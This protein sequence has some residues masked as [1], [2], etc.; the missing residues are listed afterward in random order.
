MTGLWLRW[1]GRD[2]RRRWLLVVAIALV[3][4]LGTGTYAALTSTSTWRTRSNDASFALLHLHD[5]EA[6]MS[7][8]STAPE[9]SLTAV[10]RGLPAAAD[11]ERVQERLIVP[12]QLS[13]RV[14]ARDVLTPGM[15][16]GTPP[17]PEDAAVDAL[18]VVAGRAPK[19]GEAGPT[20]VLEHK[21]ARANDLPD[22]GMLLVSG[23]RTVPYVGVGVT[24]EDFVVTGSGSGFIMVE[25][26][27]GVAY[28][29]LAGAQEIAGA[30]GRV[31]DV[32]LLL[33]PGADRGRLQQQLT[34]ALA[35]ADPPLSATVS[36]RD[37]EPAYTILY[38]DIEGDEQFWTIVSLLMLAGATFAS[39][40]LTARVV[41]GERREI[42]IGMA[43]GRPSPL[44]ALRPAMLGVEIAVMGV[45]LGLAVGFAL[46]APL[47]NLYQTL[48]PLPVW[49]TPFVP[50][51]F[52]RAAAVGVLLPLLAVAWPVW[53]AVRV[54]PVD[55]I[56]VGHLAGRQVGAGLTHLA[57]RLPS[58][59]RSYWH[60]PARNL[61]RTPRRTLLTALGVAMAIAV[62]VTVGGLIASMDRTI[63]RADAETTRSSAN[64]LS[65]TLDTFRPLDDPAVRAL[66]DVPGVASVVTGLQ[67]G[68][69]ARTADG[70]SLD[71]LVEVLDMGTAPWTPTITSGA[72][73]GGLVLT[74]TAA[75]DLG[76]RPGDRV[77]LQ[78][79][80]TTAGGLRLVESSVP[81]AGLHPFPL[82][83]MTYL[84]AASAGLFGLTGVTNLA[85]VLPTPGT[86]PDTVR[87]QLFADPAVASVTRPSDL[88]DAFRDALEQLVGILTVV[89][90][91]TL[92]LALLI[93]FNAASISAD[94]RRRENATMMAYGLPARTLLGLATVESVLI[95]LLGTVLGIGMG[96]LAM[97]WIVLVQL[98]ETLPDIGMSAT[99]GTGTV[100]QALLLGVLALAVA[101]LFVSRRLRRMDLPGTLRVVE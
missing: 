14:G 79:P 94:E 78:H 87:R 40:S 6:Q 17:A 60:M 35:A 27:F 44:L 65:V 15:I 61:L 69:T 36:T 46:I 21:Y 37:D 58:P 30:P 80:Q 62:I 41:E 19:A 57:R 47:R 52:V 56:R 9:G 86:D 91:V 8:G 76:V 77:T 85:Q 31:N 55:A 74:E 90:A 29:T 93:A 63:G 70:G 42:G 25:A 20:V 23:G 11:V 2:L 71:L 66:A 16:V 101:P 26:A 10:V 88:A 7:T 28:T 48:L 49:E 32:V 83:A 81:V 1:L 33:R 97:R 59:G 67:V 89:A 43:L 100:G 39:V 13:S 82:R 75:R 92:L 54:Q 99:L 4:A 22:T 96:W 12:T 38:Q 5:L 53:R 98:R 68:G 51:P 84:D 50:G 45:L 73:T 18:H 24:P 72:A 3:I 34:A 64:R 95:G